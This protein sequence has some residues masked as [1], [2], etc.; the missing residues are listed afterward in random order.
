[1]T[2]FD[3][4]ITRL[5]VLIDDMLS[6]GQILLE[7]IELHPVPMDLAAVVREEVRRSEP[8]LETARCSVTLHADEP[9]RGYWDAEKVAHVVKKLL[10]NAM[11]FGAG[12]PIEIEV[13]DRPRTAR[14]VVVDHGIG[15]EPDA[16]P[17]IF[18]RFERAV[19]PAFYGGL[20]IGLFIV[21]HLVEA[22]GGTITA[23]STPHVE[24]RFTVDLPSDL[25]GP[26]RT[27]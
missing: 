5:K 19:S 10:A 13:Q 3:R 27:P 26:R 22:L 11:K 18:E 9:A 2:L 8:S 7:R 20:G 16:L 4:Q 17:H 23:R 14:L 15:I 1:V 24:T 12:A 25:R 21:R 6:V